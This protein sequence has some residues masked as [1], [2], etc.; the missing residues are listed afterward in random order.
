MSLS[1]SLPENLPWHAQQAFLLLDGATVSDLP[2][3][4]KKLN[5]DACIF[6]LYDR[7]PFASLRDISPLL[8]RVQQPDEPVFQFFLRQAHNEWGWLLFS[9]APALSIA[10]HLKQ[11]LTVELPEGQTVLLRLAD[12]AVMQALFNSGDQRLF[13]PLCDVVI[14]DSASTH[15]HRHRPRRPEC[16]EMPNPYRLSP[17][18]NAALDRVDRR[19][20]LLELDAH[21][22]RHFPEHH[23]GETVLQRW[24]MLEQRLDE[25]HAL[26][27]SDKSELFYYANVMAWLAGATLEQRARINH[28]LQA[29]SLQP[30]GECVVLATELA[31]RW[32][33]EREQT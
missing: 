7:P 8:V 28:L 26:G 2:G 29:P 24:P 22:L 15:W 20:A 6:P 30:P 11:L 23:S 18:Q 1:T 33:I 19:R 21:L 17:E 3:R 16:P 25:A 4:I 32:A 14:A 10:R 9:H 27:L 13:G 5:P 31:Q 12:A